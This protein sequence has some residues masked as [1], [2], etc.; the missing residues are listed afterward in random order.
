[1]CIFQARSADKYIIFG[2]FKTESHQCQDFDV[3]TLGDG[4]MFEHLAKVG[5]NLNQYT[6]RIAAVLGTMFALLSVMR[7][8]V[9]LSLVAVRAFSGLVSYTVV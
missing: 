5:T 2:D 9:R 6:I 8:D 4:R 1:M 3:Y 7:A